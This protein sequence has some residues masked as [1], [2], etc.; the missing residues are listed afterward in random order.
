MKFSDTEH[1]I[2]K[3][4]N[5]KLKLFPALFLIAVCESSAFTWLEGTR[6]MQR[7]AEVGGDLLPVQRGF[8]HALG[9]TGRVLKLKRDETS[10]S[11]N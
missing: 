2:P 11:Q 7:L 6:E 1:E 8:A 4:R 5:E 3:K 10:F 9:L